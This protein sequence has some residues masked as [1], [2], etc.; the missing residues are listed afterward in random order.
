MKFVASLLLA[1]AAVAQVAV[2]GIP[3]IDL[4]EFYGLHQVTLVLAKQALGLSV[5]QPL[6]ASKTDAEERLLDIERVVS[7]RLEAVCCDGDKNI[8]YVGIEERDAPT[9]EVRAAPGGA[10]ALPEAVMSAFTKF[11]T[12]TRKRGPQEADFSLVGQ[13]NRIQAVFPPLM[14]QNLDITREV[15]RLSG[16]EFQRSLAA[17]LLPYARNKADIV[18]DLHEALTDND[19]NVRTTAI[20][21]LIALGQSGARVSPTWFVP[22][23]Q[24]LAWSDRTQ[25][26]WA[27]EQ[28]TR[29]RDVVLLSQLRGDALDSLIEMSRWQ[30]EQHAYPAFMLVGRVAGMTD[31]SIRDAWLRFGRDTVVEA[32]KKKAR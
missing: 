17:Y 6:P 26:V 31:V 13:A 24:S 8:L 30:T 16:D 27:L 5:G 3:R 22:I 11:Q 15:L 25:A 23:L 9:Y 20:R 12:Q 19:A 2:L 32:A 4:I 14:E 10:V 21:G 28:L 29:D 18:E 1:C 7:A